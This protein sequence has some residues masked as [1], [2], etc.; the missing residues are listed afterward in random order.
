MS[1]TTFFYRKQVGVGSGCE[2][3]K[4]EEESG[5]P[6]AAGKKEKYQHSSPTEEG[7]EDWDILR[8]L[9]EKRRPSSRK[10]GRNSDF[11]RGPFLRAE[12]GGKVGG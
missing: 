2:T 11:R 12:Q 3:D 1:R 7:R 5:A 4:T 6:K 10:R 9:C 8:K